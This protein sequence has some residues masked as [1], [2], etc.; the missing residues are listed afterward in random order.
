VKK[1][2]RIAGPDA[3]SA[4]ERADEGS[5]E[6]HERDDGAVDSV[7]CHH[8]RAA[9]CGEAGSRPDAE[10]VTDDVEVGVRAQDP[11]QPDAVVALELDLE[12]AVPGKAAGGR[13]R[14]VEPL[15]QGRDDD[16]ETGLEPRV[17]R[18]CLLLP[19]DLRKPPERSRDGQQREQHEVEEQL[20][21]EAGHRT[22]ALPS[23][24]T[25]SDIFKVMTASA[26]NPNGGCCQPRRTGA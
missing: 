11:G 17:R 15:L 20:Q 14:R 16:A 9:S 25:R 19:G 18:V 26:D 3:R 1:D 13:L 5:I 4:G 24:T 7:S 8:V 12:G 21:L 23:P 22:N 10:A 2:E 6:R